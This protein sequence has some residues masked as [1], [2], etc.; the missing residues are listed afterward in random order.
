MDLERSSRFC[1]AVSQT[2]IAQPVNSWSCVIFLIVGWM[3]FSRIRKSGRLIEGSRTYS[4]LYAGMVTLI[5]LT[6]FYGHST[7]SF[8]GGLADFESMFLLVSF[9]LLLGVSC[10]VKISIRTL[11]LMLL[12]LNI[13]L[14]YVSGLPSP[15]TDI[16]FAL[17]V[18]AVIAMELLLQFDGKRTGK[19][20]FWIAL[21]LLT[22]G[23]AIWQL[24][25][26]GIWC[27]PD[28]IIQGHAIWHVL[29]ASSAGV[30]YWYLSG[31]INP[32][33]SRS[34]SS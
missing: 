13:P 17:F 8:W 30:L 10:F 14:T 4:Y 24:D 9:I 23:F 12:F 15:I 16:T 19:K 34:K 11:L 28:S 31:T 25:T 32:V 5:G 1:E 18:T 6:S 29:T 21:G 27:N 7:L 22:V 33:V 20:Y 3:I 26:R 2:G